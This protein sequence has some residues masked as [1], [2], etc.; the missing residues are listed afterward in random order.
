[1]III[2]TSHLLEALGGH[3]CCSVSGTD[4]RHVDHKSE[5][6]S[7]PVLIQYMYYLSLM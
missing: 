4:C 3:A 5:T 1:M 6:Y 2:F 7:I